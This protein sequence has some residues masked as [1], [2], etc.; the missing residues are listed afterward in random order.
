M[1]QWVGLSYG[2][3]ALGPCS[4]RLYLLAYWLI[5]Y[6]ETGRELVDPACASWQVQIR[7]SLTTAPHQTVQKQQSEGFTP[8]S[9]HHLIFTAILDR[10]KAT[11]KLSFISSVTS[12][13]WEKVSVQFFLVW[14]LFQ[15]FLKSFQQ[16]KYVSLQT[17]LLLELSSGS[18]YTNQN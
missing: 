15:E 3:E 2:G 12:I 17:S 5:K 18:Y 16:Q 11:R 8:G 14:V 1:I 13:K 10:E 9:S 7:V 4:Q 6:P